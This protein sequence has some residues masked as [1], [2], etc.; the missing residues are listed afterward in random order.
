MT[1][2]EK[3]TADYDEGRNMAAGQNIRISLPPLVPVDA[4]SGPDNDAAA[5]SDGEGTEGGEGDGGS[6]KVWA[7]FPGSVDSSN[8]LRFI[9]HCNIS[10]GLRMGTYAELREWSVADPDAFWSAFF[11]HSGLVASAKGGRVRTQDVP[12]H[13]TRF[14]PDARLNRARYVADGDRLV[15]LP[16]AC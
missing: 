3:T 5:G 8:V 9:A 12:F 6:S 15:F 13:L 16:I 7:P 11:D 1:E 10:L 2:E 14:F 4:D